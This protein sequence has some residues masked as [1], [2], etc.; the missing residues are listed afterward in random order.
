M[1]SASQSGAPIGVII[2]ARRRRIVRK[3]EERQAVSAGSARTLADLN[4][5]D[6]RHVQKL[7][8]AGVL[9]ATSDGRY[10]LNVDRWAELREDRRRRAMMLLALVGLLVLVYWLIPKP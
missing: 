10:Y 5:S 9:S 3:F 8:D 2:T 7:K 6:S 4:V 1:S